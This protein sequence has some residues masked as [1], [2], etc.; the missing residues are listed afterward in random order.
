[1]RIFKFALIISMVTFSLNAFSQR[2]SSKASIGDFGA[3][4][5]EPEKTNKPEKT[6]KQK[7]EDPNPLYPIDKR[8]LD[9]INEDEKNYQPPAPPPPPAKIEKEPR[10]SYAAS[11]YDQ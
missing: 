4:S 9:I 7:F 1:M 3:S 6:D 5:N 8:L 2:N 10:P 11:K